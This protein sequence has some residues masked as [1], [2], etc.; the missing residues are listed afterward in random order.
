MQARAYAEKDGEYFDISH[1]LLGSGC[2]GSVTHGLV[3]PLD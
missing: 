3:C 2:L 1:K